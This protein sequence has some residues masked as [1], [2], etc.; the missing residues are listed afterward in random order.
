MRSHPIDVAITYSSKQEYYVSKVA[1]YLKRSGI[2]VFYLPFEK[3][4]IIGEDLIVYLS[5]VYKE[6]AELCVMFIS[7]EYVEGA[8][9]K[10]ELKNALE[11][12]LTQD[13]SYIL[14]I[15]FDDSIVPGL[16]ESIFYLRTNDY[17]EEELSEII[18]KKFKKLKNIPI[19]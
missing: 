4:N 13:S 19:N 17:T 16:S 6:W 14:P 18:A 2:E 1:T 8:W 5:R 9:P 10:L 15:R 7:K 12:Q 11:R 3:A